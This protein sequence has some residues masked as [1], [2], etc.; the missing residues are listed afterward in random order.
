V[1]LTVVGEPGRNTMWLNGE[2]IGESGNQLVCPLRQLGGGAGES[3]V[4][5]I[6]KLRVINRVLT[7]KE[8]GR[9]A[10]LDIPDNQ[11]AK[12]KVTATASDTAHAFTPELAT[13]EDP[14]SRWSSGPT[15]AP[16]SLAIDL[17]RNATFNT[18]AIDWE[19]ATPGEYHVEVS[20]DG[21][22]WKDVF[23]GK[24]EPGRTTA[25]FANATGRH[26]RIVMSKPTTGWGYS[27]HEVEV[28]AMKAPA[29][30]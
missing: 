25:R 27:I 3:F 19:N 23:T 24:A 9:A 13:D 28:L 1:T 11:A 30:R 21:E 7:P 29:K 10:G 15:Q 2:K 8:I 26:V 20:A 22:K 12:A 6:R 5:S 17:G 4:G 14:K 18:V 16:Q